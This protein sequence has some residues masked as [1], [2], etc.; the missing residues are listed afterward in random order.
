MKASK[1]DKLVAQL[2]F[3]A[4]FPVM[5]IV[6]EENP[7]FKQKWENVEA[8]VQFRGMDDEGD[9]VCHLIFNKGDLRVVQ[10]EYENKPDLELTFNTIGKMVKMFKGSMTSLPDMKCIFK[11][12][13]TKPGLLIT[14]IMLLL[15]LMLMMSTEDPTD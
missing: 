9:L 11:G 15:Q 5:K 10:G 12:L 8:V 1:Q 6:L 14:T 13:F 2:F 3:R 4:A 7:K